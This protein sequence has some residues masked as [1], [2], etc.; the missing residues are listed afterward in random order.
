MATYSFTVVLQTL[1][2][3]GRRHNFSNNFLHG[4]SC[5]SKRLLFS[6]TTTRRR[7]GRGKEESA[8]IQE[9]R[10]NGVSKLNVT[11]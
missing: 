6:K 7:K 9:A 3:T 1:D 8:T 5:E 11:A 2:K 4:H 10:N